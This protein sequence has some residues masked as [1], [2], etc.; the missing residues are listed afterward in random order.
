MNTDP[1]TLNADAAYTAAALSNDASNR[2]AGGPPITVRQ[3]F[4]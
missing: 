2:V 3:R 4:S 1:F